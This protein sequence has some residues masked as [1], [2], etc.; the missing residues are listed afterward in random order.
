MGLVNG[1]VA[2]IKIG[3]KEVGYV[4]GVDLS[5]ETN[6][7]DIKVLGKAWQESNDSGIKNW[8]V[9]ID[10]YFDGTDAG[11]AELK[12]GASIDIEIYVDETHFYEGNCIVESMK[13][14]IKDGTTEIS[15]SAKGNGEL[16]Y[17]A[18]VN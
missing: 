14:S 8:K 18:Y 1:A 11:Q 17:P 2:K 10:G 9:D 12:A 15:G 4:S 13:T 7:D 5:V 16:T 6:V 3:T